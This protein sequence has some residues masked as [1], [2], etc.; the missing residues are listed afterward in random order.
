MTIVSIPRAKLERRKPRFRCCCS[1]LTFFFVY[2]R[3]VSLCQVHEWMN[4]TFWLCYIAFWALSI[5]STMW[6]PPDQEVKKKVTGFFKRRFSKKHG[7]WKVTLFVGHGFSRKRDNWPSLRFYMKKAALLIY[8][9]LPSLLGFGRWIT[10]FWATGISRS[11]GALCS[12][13]RRINHRS[14]SSLLWCN[15]YKLYLTSG[16]VWM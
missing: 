1:G 7:P 14:C 13:N 6:H 11:F 10:D 4:L 16:W 9:M 3:N 5:P 15:R 2:N 8:W 12:T